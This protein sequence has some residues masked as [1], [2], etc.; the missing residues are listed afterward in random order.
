MRVKREADGALR[1]SLE[2]AE[3]A[4]LRALP[5][6]L[7]QVFQQRDSRDRVLARLFP[8]TY[9]DPRQEEEYR[10]LL[11]KDL[12]ERR[13]EGIAAFEKALALLR[14]DRGRLEAVIAP[15][16]LDTWLCFINDFRLVLGTLLDIRDD[17]WH[18]FDEKHP[19][20]MELSLLEM[21]TW[22]EGML[23]EA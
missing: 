23:L 19:Q 10:R 14:E 13:L 7:R 2:P 8:R 18:T 22:L 9:R 11:G 21:L 1:L 17:S 5:D 4:V 15:A 3:A 6:Q 16:E 20:A 12:L